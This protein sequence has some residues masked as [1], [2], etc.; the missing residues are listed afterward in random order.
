M[1]NE[2]I[3]IELLAL[4]QTLDRYLPGFCKRLEEARVELE[5]A[6]SGRAPEEPRRPSKGTG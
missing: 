5:R 2:E 1:D 4:A 6:H 3:E